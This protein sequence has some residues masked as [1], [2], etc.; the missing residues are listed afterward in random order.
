MIRNF[1][2]KYNQSNAKRPA[3]AESIS[4][5]LNIKLESLGYNRF[6]IEKINEEKFV[7]TSKDVRVD[8][9]TIIKKFGRNV[10]ME[11]NQKIQSEYE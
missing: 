9:K 10:F 7:F 1:K 6:S 2:H 5:E 8:V 3:L 4:K 11:Y